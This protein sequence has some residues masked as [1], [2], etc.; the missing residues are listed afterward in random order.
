M[1]AKAQQIKKPMYYYQYSMGGKRGYQE[2]NLGY[3]ARE[4]TQEEFL[5]Y[6]FGKFSGNLCIFQKRSNGSTAN[7]FYNHKNIDKMYT[8]LN[9]SFGIDTYISYSTFYRTNK[10]Y[11][12]EKLRTQSNIVKT[13][14][15]VQDLDYYK[16]P[17][18]DAD[19]LKQLGEM[20]DDSKIICPNFIVSTGQGYQ[21]I[22]MV[23]PFKNIAGYANDRDWS[24][25]Q[26]HLYEELRKFNSD[27]VVKNPSAVTRLPGTKHRKSGNLVYGYLTNEAV[28]K[29]KDMLFYY[30]IT[31][32]PDRL[33]KPKKPK[34]TSKNVTRMVSNWN[35][36]TL[37]KQ[38][39][40]DIFT[41]VQ[42]LNERKESYIGK[43]NWLALVLR[44]HALVS[45]DGDY[46]YARDRVL[47]LCEMMDM[48][49]TTE[50]EIMRRSGPAEKYYEDWI[51]GTWDKTKYMRGG[52]FYTN[53]RM[54]D[55]MEAKD[56]YYLQWKM[57]TI[58]I[59]NNKYEAAR[60][61]FERRSKGQV[62]GTMD[63]YIERRTE[64]KE[65]KL[66]K[67]RQ[68]LQNNPKMKQKELAGN[69]G[70]TPRYIRD[71]KK[72]L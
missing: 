24:C 36:Y 56:D 53:A 54:L 40:E 48:S 33:V 2:R 42:I 32:T 22:W 31:P 17:M 59:K 69:L 72:Q 66:E 64:E 12:E 38:R 46:E 15:L 51:N 9:K 35:E 26:E 47:E 49:D 25:L 44:F 37:N 3:P 8:F 7:T 63:E 61:H 5:T 13:Y 6:I 55:L 45:T 50:E 30:G 18:S 16:L 11:K 34:K 39:E 70:V 60:K 43:R 28:L 1:M 14:M 29:L 23:E 68:L 4:I 62:Q 71:L 52:L 57:K 65:S 58:K 10:K 19:F 41:Y 20:I 67:L 27:S 21:L